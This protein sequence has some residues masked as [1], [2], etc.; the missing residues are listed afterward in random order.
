MLISFFKIA[1]MRNKII[2]FFTVLVI[3]SYS[4]V[5]TVYG[6]AN[7]F[8]TSVFNNKVRF[9]PS[10]A[11]MG[12][13]Y[14]FDASIKSS[15]DNS[16]V[17]LPTELAFSA[18]MPV[19]ET[20]GVGV[21]FQS[22][23]GGLL[24]QTLF[25]FSYAYGIQLKED[26]G[27]RFGIAAGFK[28]I[29]AETAFNLGN[30]TG[31]PND[32]AISAY[33]S[34]PPSFYNAFSVTMHSEHLEVQLVAPNLTAPL[35]NKNLQSLDYLQLQ[36]GVTYHRQIGGGR[37]LS[38]DSYV[39]LFAG[40]MKYKQSSS[41]LTGG[42][43]LNANGFLSGNLQ[44]NTAGVITAGIGIPIDKSYNIFVNYSIGGLYSNAIYGGGGVVEV[45]FNCLFKTK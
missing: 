42:V 45:H 13:G 18:D 10:Q 37:L 23:T 11:G 31:D 43:L 27:L 29:R 44:Y 38:E 41:I 39:K 20:A 19:S 12:K 7:Y 8:S 24:K 30:V 21:V 35:Q 14:N 28:N 17:G 32:P 40:L 1:A 2:K 6:Q 33:N 16:Q 36:A 34:I 25:N 4:G 22:Q 9:N 5:S 26:L 15:R 3:M